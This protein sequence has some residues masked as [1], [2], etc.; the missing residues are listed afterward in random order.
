MSK[1]AGPTRASEADLP[2]TP[3]AAVQKAVVSLEAFPAALS[4]SG[5]C[6]GLAEVS[7]CRQPTHLLLPAAALLPRLGAPP[8]PIRAADE[9]CAHHGFCPSQCAKGLAPQ[10][11]PCA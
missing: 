7:P 1:A 8:M 11:D 5:A 2:A 9:L 3:V 4:G 6:L 10:A